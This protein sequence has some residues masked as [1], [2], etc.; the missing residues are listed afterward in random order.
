MSKID[1]KSAYRRQHFNAKTAVKSLTQFI[2]DN[3]IFLLMDI[4]LTFGGKPCPSEWGCIADPV[5][6]LANNNLTCAE[7][8]PSTTHSPSKNKFP[9]PT[10]VPEHIPSASEKETM[11]KPPAEDYAKCDVYIDD[12]A[13]IGTDIPGNTSSLEAAT[14]LALHIFGRPISTSEPIPRHPIISI[15]KL[16]AEV[17]L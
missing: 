8:N 5:T 14:P 1:Y 11:V 17:Y 15:S 4:P 10:P 7:W 12:T 9:P 3:C 13:A 2:I 6:N 16:I